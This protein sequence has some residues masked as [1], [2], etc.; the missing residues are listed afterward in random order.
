M[1][2]AR[3]TPVE[4]TNQY[5]WSPGVAAMPT[6]GSVDLVLMEPRPGTAPDR[7]T[8]PVL[9][10]SQ[11]EPSTPGAL[12]AG[13]GLVDQGKGRRR[14][15]AGH[16]RHHYVATRAAIGGEIGGGGDPVRIGHTVAVAPAPA[17]TPLAPVRG[18]AK[19]HRR[20]YQ[21]VAIGVGDGNG[22]GH[23]KSVPSSVL[24][25]TPTPAVR[26]AATPAW[27]V[28]SKVATELTPAT[29]AV[30]V[31]APAVVPAVSAGWWQAALVGL[32]RALDPAPAK[33]APAPA[34]AD[35]V[36]VDRG[37]RHGVAVGVG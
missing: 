19:G 13:A 29:L 20:P 32:R 5:P 10:T 26:L 27:T 17:N 11:Y 3:T 1:P 25:E 4:V 2:K 9:V 34:V 24:C 18:A 37:P 6:T 36:E 22:Q 31:K 7:R 23:G 30:T 16:R 21:R 33:V 28:R 8:L 14:A 12:A 15:Q 35:H